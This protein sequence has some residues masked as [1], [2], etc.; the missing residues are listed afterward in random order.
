MFRW[1]ELICG[2]FFY[3]I[4]AGMT[5][6]IAMPTGLVVP[7]LFIGGCMGRLWGLGFLEMFDALGWTNATDPGV[8]AV[9]GSAAFMAGSGQ[10]MMFLAVV[11]LEITNDLTYMPAIAL[12]AIIACFTGSQFTH[13]LYH[14]LIH[15][16]G[17]PYLEHEPELV[18]K[19]QNVDLVMAGGRDL[20][21]PLRTLR[22]DMLL[23]DAL[24]QIWE[25]C[26]QD[27]MALNDHEENEEARWHILKNNYY[28]G[29]PIVD[30]DGSFVGCLDLDTLRDALKP[31]HMLR[32][33]NV[34]AVM[35]KSAS[36][37]TPDWP[38]DQA[39][40]LFRR[41]GLRRISV[42]DKSNCPV[43]IITR[44]NLLSFFVEEQVDEKYGN[45][46]HPHDDAKDLVREENAVHLKTDEGSKPYIRGQ[47]HHKAHATEDEVISGL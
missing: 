32:S 6:G 1:H 33:C 41:M 29:F 17:L 45:G 5:T 18:H 43:G 3:F 46:H 8:F 16:A 34:A 22:D 40:H 36:T 39:Y 26:V 4:L 23:D 28:H 12:A 15:V 42:V 37:C 13:G 25:Y 47:M 38:L 21:K 2:F 14:E 27:E 24:Q 7:Y 35:D 10:I 20:K 11:T 31:T 30:H 9:V 44:L 19:T